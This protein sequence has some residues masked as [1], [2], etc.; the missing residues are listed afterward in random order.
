MQSVAGAGV[1]VTGAGSGIGAAIACRLAAEGARV[2]VNDID[3]VAAATVAS[4]AWGCYGPFAGTQT[5]GAEQGPLTPPAPRLSSW[6]RGDRS[7]DG[8]PAASCALIPTGTSLS[9]VR[10]RSAAAASSPRRAGRRAR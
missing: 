9:T 4:R 5:P 1:V 6:S 2:I 7:P 8:L 10:L 3:A